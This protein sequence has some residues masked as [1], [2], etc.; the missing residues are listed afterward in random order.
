MLNQTPTSHQPHLPP[1]PP[2]ILPKRKRGGQPGNRNAHKHGF[3]AKHNPHPLA[4]TLPK[5]KQ[6]IEQAKENPETLRNQIKELDRVANKIADKMDLLSEGTPLWRVLLKQ[7]L[8]IISRISQLILYRHRLNAGARLLNQLAKVSTL[9]ITREFKEK[10][11]PTHPVFLPFTLEDLSTQSTFCGG[12]NTSGAF[13]TDRHWF[14]IEPL[15]TN[16]R[17]EL[18]QRA[19]YYGHR[20][21]R[22]SPYPDRF[23]LDG[24]LWKLATASRWDELPSEYPRRRCQRLYRD[25]YDTGRIAAIYEILHQDLHVY[26]DTSLETL[27]EGGEYKCHA[28]KI[29]YIPKTKPDW[30]HTTALLLLQRAYFNNRKLER[31]NQAK[32]PS[33]RMPPLPYLRS[34]PKKRIHNPPPPGTF[35]IPSAKNHPLLHPHQ[36]LPFYHSHAWKKWKNMQKMNRL[37]R[38]KLEAP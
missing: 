29:I 14:I 23:L 3:Y 11:I 16:Y 17:Q 38:Q 21:P 25:L 36:F 9:L 12:L 13:L 28:S 24:I 2:P 33:F 32:L 1:I 35:T 4:S 15:L 22:R 20:R 27:V 8:S 7:Y 34:K 10:G 18:I 26:G 31:E 30:Q 5:V 19:E 6:I 37:M